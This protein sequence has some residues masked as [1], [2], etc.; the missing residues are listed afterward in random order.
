M[1][2]ADSLPEADETRDDAEVTSEMSAPPEVHVD[3]EPVHEHA[4]GAA[5]QDLT[6]SSS[7]DPNHDVPKTTRTPSEALA[8]AVEEQPASSAGGSSTSLLQE[9]FLELGQTSDTDPEYF[10]RVHLDGEHTDF[11]STS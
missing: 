9:V 5:V 2:A 7:S 8:E 10:P 6:S 1:E 11:G 3:E 4:P